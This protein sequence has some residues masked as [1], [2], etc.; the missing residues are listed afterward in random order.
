MLTISKDTNIACQY[1]PQEKEISQNNE[2]YD[3]VQLKQEAPKDVSSP[4]SRSFEKNHIEEIT[5][6]SQWEQKSK[7]K[8]EEKKVA[9]ALLKDFI[10]SSLQNVICPKCTKN[11]NLDFKKIDPVIQP[12]GCGILGQKIS[13]KKNCPNSDCKNDIEILRISNSIFSNW[14]SYQYW[15]EGKYRTVDNNDEKKWLKEIINGK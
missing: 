6:Q 7:K 8:F 12:F 15:D 2:N 1:G 11:F 4:N 9:R 3:F 5:I 13:Y 14:K 10:L